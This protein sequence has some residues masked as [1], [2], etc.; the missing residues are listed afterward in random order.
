M[1]AIK[2]KVAM[3]TKHLDDNFEDLKKVQEQ[4][5]ADSGE[6]A[7]FCKRFKGGKSV[8]HQ[9]I[10]INIDDLDEL[11]KTYDFVANLAKAD[12]K[13]FA[14]AYQHKAKVQANWL[15]KAV[16]G[17]EDVLPEITRGI[18]DRDVKDYQKKKKMS[19]NLKIKMLQLGEVMAV[20]LKFLTM[21]LN[22]SSIHS[23]RK[24]NT[25]KIIPEIMAAAE[26]A[27]MD[28]RRTLRQL[29]IKL[30]DGLDKYEPKSHQRNYETNRQALYTDVKNVVGSRLDDL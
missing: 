6:I 20:E 28:T 30:H 5:T 12:L 17:H 22:F 18:S 25:Y 4:V 24:R 3:K 10:T 2:F 14:V 11:R 29:W 8:Q 23:A 7:K 21:T 27:S 15:Q 1:K 16:K 13:Q 9:D 26:K 19:V